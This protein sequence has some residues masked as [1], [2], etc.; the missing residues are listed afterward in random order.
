M[1][2]LVFDSIRL[3]GRATIAFNSLSNVAPFELGL[4][5]NLPTTPVPLQRK[6]VGLAPRQVQSGTPIEYTGVAAI[7]TGSSR[8]SPPRHVLSRPTPGNPQLFRVRI[9]CATVRPRWAHVAPTLGARCAPARRDGS[10]YQRGAGAAVA[11][12]LFADH[13]QTTGGK[14]GV[15]RRPWMSKFG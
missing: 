5:P 6:Q 13:L 11:P 15:P 8:T 3:L 2:T 1:P 12:L 4:A 14:L 9:C 10:S 7:T